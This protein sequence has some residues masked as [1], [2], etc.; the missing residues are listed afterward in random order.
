VTL[1]IVGQRPA[2]GARR[3]ARSVHP[4]VRLSTALSAGRIVLLRH[5]HRVR[6]TSSLSP[7]GRLIT[8]TPRRRLAGAARYTVRIIVAVSPAG[9]QV[10]GRWSFWTR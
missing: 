6:G 7:D 2:P 9:A 1:T 3:V 10:Q 8:F 4:A 5:G